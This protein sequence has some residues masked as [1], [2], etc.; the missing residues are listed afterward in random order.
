MEKYNKENITRLKE[1]KKVYED[2]KE[3][4]N[5]MK[6]WTEYLEREGIITDRQF[7]FRTKVKCHQFLEFSSQGRTPGNGYKLEKL[8]FRTDIGRY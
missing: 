2:P 5:Y 6:Q 3:M 4:R 8:R 7:G 1:N